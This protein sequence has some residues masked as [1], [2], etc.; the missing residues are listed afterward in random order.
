MSQYYNPLK[1]ITS[2]SGVSLSNNILDGIVEY[3]DWALL[4]KGNFVNVELNETA[5][6]GEDYSTLR[7]AASGHYASGQIWEGFRKNWVWQSGLTSPAPHVG[8]NHTLPGISGI[9]VDST[10]YP[11]TT[12]GTYAYHID[13]LNGRVVFDSAIPTGS[14]VQVQH[15]YK[16]INVLYT[17]EAP[18]SQQI[19]TDTHQPGRT[20]PNVNQGR[21][22][23]TPES[24]MQ[25]PAMLF[26]VA[27]KRDFRGYQLG[28]GQWVDTDIMVYCFAEDP[29]TRNFLMDTVSLQNNGTIYILDSDKIAS[30]LAMPIDYR[31]VPVSGALRY[32][33][34]ISNYQGGRVRIKNMNVQDMKVHGDELFGAVVRF[35]AEGIKLNI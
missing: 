33:D 28:G 24:R 8:T 10:F 22:D 14:T 34:L 7:L 29:I 16:Y 32:P 1:G 30:N 4:E 12:T 15:S 35:T 27:P 17:D 13:Y 25:L 26:A 21:W 6:N 20:F 31:G 3:F 11:T 9:W 19:Q 5:P 2:V 18:W 23:T